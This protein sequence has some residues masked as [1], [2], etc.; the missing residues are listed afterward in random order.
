MFCHVSEWSKRTF[1]NSLAWERFSLLKIS[2]SGVGFGV[3]LLALGS[4]AAQALIV[5][6]FYDEYVQ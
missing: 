2:N 3:F 1:L 4:Q 5:N 6:N